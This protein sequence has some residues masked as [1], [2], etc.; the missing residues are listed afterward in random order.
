MK[1]TEAQKRA[2]YKY[3]SNRDNI[4]IRPSKEDGA[5]IREAAEGANQSVQQY[6]LQAIQERMKREGTG[7]LSIFSEKNN[8]SD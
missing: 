7:V 2:S 4:M 8:D 3:N 1:S 5:K 6:V